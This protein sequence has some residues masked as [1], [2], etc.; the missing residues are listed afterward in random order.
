MHYSDF[1]LILL[2]PTCRSLETKSCWG[3]LEPSIPGV[4]CS[5][6]AI[7]VVCVASPGVAQSALPLWPREVLD[8]NISCPSSVWLQTHVRPSPSPAQLAGL[9][10]LTGCSCVCH[11]PNCPVSPDTYRIEKLHTHCAG[12]GEAL[13]GQ[14]GSDCSLR[15][16]LASAWHCPC[17]GLSGHTEPCLHT[18]FGRFR[19]RQH[20]SPP[21]PVQGCVWLSGSREWVKT[22]L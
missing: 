15:A 17:A 21:W 12:S 13:L 1:F 5:P 16:G 10:Q 6:A 14:H 8:W 19:G 9:S 18:H 7:A 22:A 2:F 3:V 4:L 11:S 20:N